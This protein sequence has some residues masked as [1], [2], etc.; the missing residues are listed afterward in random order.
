MPIVSQSTRHFNLI[1]GVQT[2]VAL[3]P[4]DGETITS[5]GTSQSN[6]TGT[7]Y[8]ARKG[9]TYAANWTG[10]KPGGGTYAGFD[11][12]AWFPIGV[13]V[14]D[15]TGTDFYT[16][17]LDLGLNT[18]MPAWNIVTLSDATANGIAVFVDGNQFPTIAAGDDPTVVGAIMGEEP[19]DQT[20]WDN[21]LAADAAWF[22]GAD[23]PGRVKWNNYGS[24]LV[25]G[26][27]GSAVSA[28]M[29]T[30]ADIITFD[31]YWFTGTNNTDQGDPPVNAGRAQQT[32]RLR[33][34]R[35]P[36]VLTASQ[37]ARGSHYG[38]T[39]SGIRKVWSA[40]QTR[41]IGIFVE[42]GAP[43]P[44]TVYDNI[45]P[46]QM[47]W[48]V[49]APVVHGARIINWFNHTFRSG[50]SFSFNNF[51]SDYYGGPG[52]EGLGI[53]AAAKYINGKITEFA[54]IL[55]SPFDGKFLMGD[56]VAGVITQPGFLTDVR[57]A[58]PLGPYGGVDAACRWQPV[59]QKHYILATTRED[60]TV[61]NIPVTFE[62]SDQGQTAATELFSG[63]TL[64]VTRGGSIPS[65]FCE[66]SDT[67]PSAADPLCYR[68]D[69]GTGATGATRPAVYRL[70]EDTIGPTDTFNN[71]S[72]LTVGME[73]STPATGIQVTQLWYWRATTA[74]GTAGVQGQIYRV[75]DQAALLDTPVTFGAPT[76]T[77][78]QS[79]TLPTPVSLT[80]GAAY[81]VTVN[82]ADG[83]YAAT[84]AFW[85]GA[86]EGVNGLS[87]GGVLYA[88]SGTTA[89]GGAQG[90]FAIGGIQYPTGSFNNGNYWVDVTAV[91]PAS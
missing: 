9:L 41:P 68:I 64:A 14:P 66:F 44:E 87:H 72:A 22:G 11:D 48:A 26:V 42:N 46:T 50:P 2:P 4:L 13:W 71:G 34:Y 32:L 60:Q 70:F 55:N 65:G 7:G 15:F 81:K 37:S 84:A 53:Y 47:K 16:R 8:Y 30:A 76:G 20:S 86:G 19:F 90:T 83:I 36:D 10:P 80:A 75:S 49:W 58:N 35:Y 27:A 25:N 78:W 12:P 61:T 56:R 85:A 43:Y 5:G 77:G 57:S 59:Q 52:V 45:T 1:T 38:T 67:I 21:L 40:D 62:M 74:Q 73:F 28:D 29:A 91:A 63:R 6:F 82:F 18:I 89:A 17:M 88:P 3:S 69:G 79:V 51:N 24:N 39:V 23:G 33:L 54:P 31:E